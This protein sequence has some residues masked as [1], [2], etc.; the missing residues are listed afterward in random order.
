MLAACRQTLYVKRREKDKAFDRSPLGGSATEGYLI[1]SPSPT[2]GAMVLASE[3]SEQQQRLR[4]SE[5]RSLR[6]YYAHEHG[7]TAEAVAAAEELWG[8]KLAPLSSSLSY[9]IS[10]PPHPH[11]PGRPSRAP[12]SRGAS[13]TPQLQ[14]A[15][16][17]S[18]PFRQE[19]SPQRAA[20]GEQD[21]EGERCASLDAAGLEKS[22]DVDQF[23]SEA[24]AEGLSGGALADLEALLRH[25][26]ARMTEQVLERRQREREQQ[27]ASQRTHTHTQSSR[28]SEHSHLEHAVSPTQPPVPAAAAAAVPGASSAASSAPD[29][30]EILKEREAFLLAS[31]RQKR[32]QR[33]AARYGEVRAQ[34]QSEGH[35]RERNRAATGRV[36]REDAAAAA[37]KKGQQLGAS[38]GAGRNGALPGAHGSLVN[39]RKSCADAQEPS[40]SARLAAAQQSMRM[41]QKEEAGAA[42]REEAGAAAGAPIGV[43]AHILSPLAELASVHCVYEYTY[44]YTTRLFTYIATLDSHAPHMRPVFCHGVSVGYSF[45]DLAPFLLLIS[46]RREHRGRER[47]SK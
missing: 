25:R 44:Y 31:L 7:N 3:V 38:A 46:D 19:T 29:L 34:R 8:Y 39:S 10:P 13:P 21:T 15:A 18:R 36:L 9:Y 23:W 33:L 17:A 28:E 16:C 43:M 6:Y 12:S 4:D 47:E 27:P 41:V 42:R 45:C 37:E 14:A 5:P 22:V 2:A 24:A 11:A 30:E 26:E 35:V 20:R 1:A 32:M 40:Q